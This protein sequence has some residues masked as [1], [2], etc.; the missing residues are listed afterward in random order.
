MQAHI[1]LKIICTVIVAVM[2]TDG[3]KIEGK[4]GRGYKWRF[5]YIQVEKVVSCEDGWE[6]QSHDT[7]S[8]QFLTEMLTVLVHSSSNSP[9]SKCPR[10]I[11]FLLNTRTSVIIALYPPILLYVRWSICFPRNFRGK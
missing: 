1:N 2:D 10:M 5:I 11:I 9:T 7:V 6:N 3:M 8:L 4:R